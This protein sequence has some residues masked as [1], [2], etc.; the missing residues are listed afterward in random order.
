M[1]RQRLTALWRRAHPSGA[2]Q[3]RRGAFSSTA[4]S[5]SPTVS[6]EKA[7]HGKHGVEKTEDHLPLYD[8]AICGGGIVGLATARELSMRHP[9]LKIVVLDKEGDIA[10]H[11]SMRNSGVIH[12]GIYYRPGSQQARFCVKGASMMY[13]FCEANEIPH[14]RIGKIIVAAT[15]EE[16]QPLRDLYER[17][18]TNGVP[19]ISLIDEEGIS[20]I[21]PNISGKMAILS[22][23]TGMVDFRKVA[24]KCADVFLARNRQNRIVT[25]FEVA[26]FSHRHDNTV[27]ILAD[28]RA[29]QLDTGLPIRPF[30][31][32]SFCTHSSSSSSKFSI[33]SGRSQSS[34]SRSSPSLSSG[35]PPL[36]STQSYSPT[37]FKQV[38]VVRARAVITAG[39]LHADRL[40]MMAGGSPYPAIVPFRGSYLELCDE[41]RHLVRRNVYPV[42]DPTLPFLGV[43]ITPTMNG[44]TVLGPNAVLSLDREAYGSHPLLSFNPRDVKDLVTFPGIWKLAIKYFRNGLYEI[45]RDLFPRVAVE[46]LRRFAPWLEEKHVARSRYVGIRAQA[47]MPDGSLVDDFVFEEVDP[48][49][50]RSGA[51]VLNVRNAPSP[52]CTASLAIAEEVC[53]RAE[54]LFGSDL[55]IAAKS[56]S[57]K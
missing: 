55:G 28:P 40:S 48:P 16:V 43:H 10:T 3:S 34:P 7:G 4:A 1:V 2:V 25:G 33:K 38:P 31:P 13:D 37:T 35:S 27:V 32:T 22:P 41:Y 11:Q 53:D 23:N 36:S 30:Q 26:A 50:G 14:E 15:E 56:D 8:V 49:S 51:K 17:A 24:K 44:T 52:G 6:Q 54:R 19:D 29:H 46:N 18:L 5:L 39:G 20:S 21:E 57:T 9:Q 47:M 45:Y 42:K 12:A